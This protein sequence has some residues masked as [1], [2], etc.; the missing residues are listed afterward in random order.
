MKAFDLIVPLVIV[1]CAGMLLCILFLSLHPS[2]RGVYLDPYG[3][4]AV[5]EC[6]A[7]C[8][9]KYKAELSRVN[10]I[11]GDCYCQ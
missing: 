6:T 10:S 3:P 5:K 11:S 8:R 7:L 1:V 9:E 4:D 2:P